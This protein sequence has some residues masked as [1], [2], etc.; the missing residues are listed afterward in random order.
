LGRK[1]EVMVSLDAIS[2]EECSQVVETLEASPG[3]AVIQH[4]DESG[5][6]DE[7]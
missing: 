1:E 4:T 5:S 7:I 2:A 6:N 3:F